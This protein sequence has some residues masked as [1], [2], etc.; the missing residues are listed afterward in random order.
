MWESGGHTR[1]SRVETKAQ[2]SRA[3]L[4]ES[5]ALTAALPQLKCQGTRLFPIS[6]LELSKVH[7]IAEFVSQAFMST[8]VTRR[9]C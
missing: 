3:G 5:L 1:V 6:G 4:E 2:P 9:S 7:L 8:R